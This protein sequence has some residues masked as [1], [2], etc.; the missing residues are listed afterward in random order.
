[1]TAADFAR[2]LTPV[3]H[4]HAEDA[5]NRTDTLAELDKFQARVDLDSHRRTR[6]RAGAAAAALTAAA[7]GVGAL[8]FGLGQS[9]APSPTEPAPPATSPEMSDSPQAP[10]STV[11]GFE[12]YESFPMTYVVPR[13]FVEP[14]RET[15][16]R[17][18]AV[19]GTS[20]DAA[21]FL[22]TRFGQVTRSDLPDDLAA[23]L[24]RTRD[25]EIVS[26]V[27]STPVGGRPAQTFTL[28]QKRG[29]A[30]TDLFCVRGGSC[31][32][33]LQDKPMDV[34]VVRTDRN[35]VLFWV[36]YL[37]ADRAKVQDPMKD[38]LSSVRW[39]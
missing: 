26:N 11:E 16:T 5:M 29:I 36:E 38:W 6:R 8:W 34:T 32:K 2:R 19:K 23:H 13:T 30:P 17:A 39:Q 10:G 31:F 21:A 24:R 7:V 3:L 1:M 20:G 25:D 37:P 33:L 22:V 15:G 4:Q 9:D 12:G 28:A 14:S 27:G 18:Y 35:L